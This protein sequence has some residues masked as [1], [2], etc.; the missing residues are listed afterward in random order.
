MNALPRKAYKLFRIRRDGTLG[1]LFINCRQRICLGD[2]L[3]A[4]CH[5]TKGYEVRPGWHCLARPHAPHLS[6]R[7]R[8]W[9]E[10]EVLDYETIIRPKS[11]GGEWFL[12]KKLRVVRQ[13]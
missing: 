9:F 2:W 12:A 8:S 7:G 11:Q 1:P 6:M 3:E 4:E 5:P 10:V 13:L